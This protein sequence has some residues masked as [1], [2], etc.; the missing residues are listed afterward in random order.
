MLLHGD[1]LGRTQSGNNNTYAQDSEL[2]WVAWDRVDEALVD[3]V[4]RAVALRRDHP[5][6][7]RSRFFSG[8]P[9]PRDEGEPLADIEWL[10]PDGT[11][12]TAEDWDTE[13]A[14][15]IG[16]FLNGHGM[17]ERD[18]RGEPINDVNFIVYF[19]AGDEA[20]AFRLPDANHG[21]RWEVVIDTT[22][23]PAEPLTAAATVDVAGKSVMVLREVVEALSDTDPS[24][25]ASVAFMQALHG[26]SASGD[27]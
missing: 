10:L 15:S 25:E 16:M 11:A 12:M 2:S 13:F 24:V 23:G 26:E 21:A 20:V 17:S 6:F 1:E 18:A 5:T 19:N 27:T 8:R 3:F 7:R 9:V 4:A 22:G 14:R